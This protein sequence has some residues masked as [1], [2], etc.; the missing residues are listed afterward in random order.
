MALTLVSLLV[1]QPTAAVPTGG[2]VFIINSG[3]RPLTF[4]A[5]GVTTGA[6]TLINQANGTTLYTKDSLPI[7]TYTGTVT[8]SSTPALTLVITFT[9]AALPIVQAAPPA[10][11]AAHLPVL[12]ALQADPPAPGIAAALVVALD[13][14]R[15]GVWQSAGVLREVCDGNGRAEFYLNEYL[16]SQFSPTAP[17]ESGTPDPALA[18]RYRARYGRAPFDGTAGGEAGTVTGLALNAALPVNTTGAALPLG[19]GPAMPY[20]S[21]P[22]TYARFQSIILAGATGVANVPT[23]A[24]N[25]SA[26]P[27]PVRQFVWLHPSGAWCWGLFSGRHEHGA[28]TGEDVSVRRPDGDYYVGGG[29]VRDTLRVFSDKIDSWATYQVLRTIRK[30]RRVYERLPSGQYL[31]VL[32]ERGAFV[33]YKETDKLFEV[34][35]TARYP[36]QVVQT[37]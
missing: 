8:D 4:T 35:F 13:V 10:L 34:N 6:E 30:A 17:D 14:L 7:G 15:A 25:S 20:S 18:I 11:V 12:L 3:T 31:P 29:D 28:E 37:F 2:V 24:V 27:C 22:A 16:K 36:V 5:T 9:I 26:W 33:E 1:V 32:L 23:V 19:L 21:V